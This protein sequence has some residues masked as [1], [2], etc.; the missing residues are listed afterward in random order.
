M[1]IIY[2]NEF[3]K[4]FKK[5]PNEIKK[6]AFEKEKLFRKDI[7]DSKLKNHKLSGKLNGC[8]AFSINF[9][10]RIIYEFGLN[11][12]IYFHSVGTHDIYK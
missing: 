11:D 8:W 7:K 5:L 2:T 1:K 9:N 10:Y 3:R 12:I 6:E 4:S